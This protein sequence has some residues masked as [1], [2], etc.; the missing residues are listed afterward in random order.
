MDIGT[1]LEFGVSSTSLLSLMEL[2]L[3]R[4]TAVALYEKISRD[5]L[6]REGCIEWLQERANQLHA[7]DLPTIIIREITELLTSL[8]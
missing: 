5:D 4:M 8:D 2:G 6:S 7:M 3:S 1:Q